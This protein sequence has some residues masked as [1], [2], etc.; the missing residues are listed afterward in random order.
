VSL[1][2]AKRGK[3]GNA[4][5]VV[6]K[7]ETGANHQNLHT[8]EVSLFSTG[9]RRGSYAGRNVSTVVTGS[10]PESHQTTRPVH[11][12]GLFTAILCRL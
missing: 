10:C 3:R 11:S 7:K 6:K 12:M 9:I 5:A 1:S 2:R 4:Q 8:T